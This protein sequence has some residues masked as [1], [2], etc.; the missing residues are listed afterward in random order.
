[1]AMNRKRSKPGDPSDKLTFWSLSTILFMFVGIFLYIFKF[2]GIGFLKMEDSLAPLERA[3]PSFCCALLCF[4]KGA[5]ITIAQVTDFF[6]SMP[7]IKMEPR[8]PDVIKSDTNKN[9]INTGR[10]SVNESDPAEESG[11]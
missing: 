6:Q 10:S 7:T 5:R 4:F 3:A 8:K 2:E 1:M 9:S 11:E